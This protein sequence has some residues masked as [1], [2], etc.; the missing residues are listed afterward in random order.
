[1]LRPIILGFRLARR[2]EDAE[3]L[4]LEQFVRLYAIGTSTLH[5][6]VTRKVPV[7]QT[8]GLVYVGCMLKE[9]HHSRS[10]RPPDELGVGRSWLRLA[11][12]SDRYPWPDGRQAA[13]VATPLETSSGSGGSGYGNASGGCGAAQSA[14]PPRI[15]SPPVPTPR[16]RQNSPQ[17]PTS[18]DSYWIVSAKRDGGPR[19]RPD[20]A[21]E[22]KN[23]LATLQV[24]RNSPPD[25]SLGFRKSLRGHP[26]CRAHREDRTPVH[27]LEPFGGNAWFVGRCA[28]PDHE[29][30]TPIF[31]I[32]PPGRY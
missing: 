25:T 26:R 28:L 7:M 29:D 14:P 12:G 19:S 30:K 10:V 21:K 32:Y 1:M 23:R 2:E 9:Q 6:R 22:I 8:C 27:E 18:F 17:S 15:T 20:A 24:L 16:P 13:S 31:Y 11:S 3:A 4:A 5:R